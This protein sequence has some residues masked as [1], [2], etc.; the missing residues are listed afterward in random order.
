MLLLSAARLQRNMD[1]GGPG[2]IYPEP[3]NRDLRKA[4]PT[5]SMVRVCPHSWSLEI[6]LGGVNAGFSK[7]M[8]FQIFKEMVC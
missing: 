6:V 4:L 1:V 2:S 5:G 7:Y 8:I 3:G